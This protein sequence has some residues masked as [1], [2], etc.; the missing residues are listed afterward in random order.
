MQF[1]QCKRSGGRTVDRFSR[2]SVLKSTVSTGVGLP[3]F[4]LN[5]RRAQA[6]QSVRADE[7]RTYR[8][9][10][11]ARFDPGDIKLS[12][13]EIWIPVPVPMAEQ[14]VEDVRTEPRMRIRRDAT[15]MVAVAG[16]YSEKSLPRP[17]QEV[18]FEASYQLESR[19]IVFDDA[20]NAASTFD[21]YQRNRVYRT[22]TRAEEKIE[23]ED[24]EIV[25]QAKKLRRG[26]DTP[27]EF[28]RAAYDWVLS[29]TNYQL[30]EGL[31]GARFCMDHGHGECGDYSALFVALCRAAGIP[32]RP[33][34]GFWAD[35]TNGWHV[36]A[37][38]MLPSGEWIPVDGS[39]GDQNEY[40][41]QESFGHRDNR[42]GILS[43]TFDISLPKKRHGKRF[44]EYL[45][46]GAWWWKGTAVGSG[47]RKPQ[48]EFTLTGEPVA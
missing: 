8:I 17:G 14:A 40:A 43:K 48:A 29:N 20:R 45:Q 27:M 37:E 42:R 26:V 9:V 34:V 13:L 10:H 30:I 15:N 4:A 6:T 35:K 2:R 32:A 36:W 46:I 39:I 24:P 47:G 16:F 28:G 1:R 3:L 11:R 25:Q 18:E 5:S 22:F 33:V 31:G 23:V 7:S 44:A 38:F 12:S 41:Y 19:R 21:E